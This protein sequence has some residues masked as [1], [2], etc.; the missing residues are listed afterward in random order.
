MRDV[1]LAV[2]PQRAALRLR[3]GGL[4]GMITGLD[5]TLVKGDS[6]TITLRFARTGRATAGAVVVDYASLDSAIAAA[7]R[8]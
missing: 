8:R 6:L 3:P 2:V 7:E 4:H 5:S 1:A